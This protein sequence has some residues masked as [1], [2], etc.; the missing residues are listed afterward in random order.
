VTCCAARLIR[1]A[2]H[3][4][5]GSATGVPGLPVALGEGDEVSAGL[6]SGI[7][8]RARR[9]EPGAAVGLEIVLGVTLAGTQPTSK[10]PDLLVNGRR[11]HTGR[12]RALYEAVFDRLARR[13]F[14]T[15]MPGMTLPNETVSDCTVRWDSSRSVPAGASGGSVVL[16]TTSLGF[17]GL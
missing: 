17:S 9:Q 3:P 1:P 2:V 14:R 10:Y 6:F 15:A 16:G 12:G 8:E 11:R 13:G 5:C 7:A 4:V